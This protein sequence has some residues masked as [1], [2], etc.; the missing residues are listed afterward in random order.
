MVTHE[1]EVLLTKQDLVDRLRVS[2]PTI[3][4][5]IVKGQLRPVRIGRI[6]RFR[7]EEV[8]RFLAAGAPR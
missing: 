5:L 3:N 6:L 1:R 8:E 7:L 2:L 4:R